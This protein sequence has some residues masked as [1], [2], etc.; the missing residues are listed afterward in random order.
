M[1][2]DKQEEYQLTDATNSAISSLFQSTFDGYPNGLT[3]YN[4]VPDFRVLAWKEDKLLGHMGVHHRKVSIR[5]EVFSVFGIVDLCVAPEVQLNNVGT[6]LIKW[7]TD[8]AEANPVDFIMLTSEINDFYL[9][10]GFVVAQNPC[11]WLVIHNHVS[12]GVFRRELKRG[13]MIK[14]TSSAEWPIGE[15]D[16]MGHMF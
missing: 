6:K 15:V 9:K 16:L 8:L 4:Q 3:Y 1:K 11:R 2:L 14:A 5:Q 10:N 13:L 12:M 7:L